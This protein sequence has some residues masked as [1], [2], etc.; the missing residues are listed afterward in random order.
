M[1]M[2]FVLVNTA[3]GAEK[4]VKSEIDKLV[5]T[6]EVSIIFGA[7]DI[8]VTFYKESIRDVKDVVEQIRKID[9]VETTLTMT[10]PD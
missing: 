7:Y 3:V 6:R 10:S 2:A 8:I 1:V 9:N 4:S 5:D